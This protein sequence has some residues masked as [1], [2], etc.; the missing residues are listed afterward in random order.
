MARRKSVDTL[1]KKRRRLPFTAK[2]KRED[3][4]CSADQR[5]IQAMCRRIA[6]AAEHCSSAGWREES[7]YLLFHF[8]TWAKARAL[9]HWI[10]R[11]GIARR[12]MPKLGPTPEE[13]A[14]RKRQALAW[15]FA[16]G[17]VREIVQAYR[18]ARRA[19]DEHLTAFNAACAV[20]RALGRANDDVRDTVEGLLDW[21]KENHREWFWRFESPAAPVARTMRPAGSDAR[22]A[23]DPGPWPPRHSPTF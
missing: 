15:G 14:D 19:G 3:P 17:A 1:D 10:D 13:V 2:I 16:T 7:G 18:R 8:T 5:E 4:F 12:P 23:S 6:G 9:Q 21:A 11:S 20:A 22:P